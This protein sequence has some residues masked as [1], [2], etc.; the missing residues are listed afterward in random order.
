VLFEKSEQVALGDP[1]HPAKP[2]RDKLAI[3][4]PPPN[5]AVPDIKCIRYPVDRVEL[6]FVVSGTAIT[7][8]GKSRL[9]L[10]GPVSRNHPQRPTIR[11]R[12]PLCAKFTRGRY[13]FKVENP[14]GGSMAMS[15]KNLKR[16]SLKAVPLTVGSPDLGEPTLTVSQIVE[17]LGPLTPDEAAAL[18]ERIRHWTRKGLLLPVDQHH[19]GTGRH[20]GYRP[21]TS[22]EVVVLNALARAGLDL[23]SRP[24]IRAALEQATAAFQKWLQAMSAGRKPP[25]L[26]LRM[27][28]GSEPTV[29]THEEL[30]RHA[31]AAET[32]IAVNLSKL[33]SRVLSRVSQ[34]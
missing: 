22:Y 28:V 4:D 5:R 23:V 6:D 26:F 3:F 32:M 9:S 34:P 12:Y 30:V 7:G 8:I 19:A 2:V 29:S 17:Q 27:Q 18:S 20:R 11:G 33:F 13:P 15:K 21:A 14:L 25:L 16:H 10:G 1:D 24:D 31:P